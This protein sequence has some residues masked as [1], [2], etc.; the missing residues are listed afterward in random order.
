MKLADPAQSICALLRIHAI[1]AKLAHSTVLPPRENPKHQTRRWRSLWKRDIPLHF[2]VEGKGIIG[3]DRAG[4]SLVSLCTAV[5]NEF[6]PYEVRLVRQMLRL[7]LYLFPSFFRLVYFR[8]P[9]LGFFSWRPYWRILDDERGY[10]S[11]EPHASST[12][13]LTDMV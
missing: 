12:V 3:R 10:G 11:S 9:C 13:N 7:M 8:Q 2:G 6:S 1:S 5:E 4:G